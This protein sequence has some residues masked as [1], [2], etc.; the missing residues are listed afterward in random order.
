SS[1]RKVMVAFAELEEVLLHFGVNAQQAIAAAEKE[2]GRIL[3]K[4][5]DA[6]KKVRLEVWD[7]GRGVPQQDEQKLFQPFFTTKPV[8][9][10][11]GLGLSVSYGIIDA[12]GGATGYFNNEW[13]GATFFIE[14][15]VAG[16]AGGAKSADDG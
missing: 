5:C 6:G 9:S 15:P 2:N 12:Y 10:G 16:D 1:V 3:I 7:D 14:L 8:G 11:T 4:L 13:S